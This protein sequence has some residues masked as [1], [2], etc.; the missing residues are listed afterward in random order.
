MV[1][2][3]TDEPEI[4]GNMESVFVPI[5]NDLAHFFNDIFR[6]YKFTLQRIDFR[7]KKDEATADGFVGSRPCLPLDLLP[8]LSGNKFYFH[9]AIGCAVIFRSCKQRCHQS[10]ERLC[11][12]L[13]NFFKLT[14]KEDNF[15]FQLWIR[16]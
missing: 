6:L 9:G 15:L 4:Y 13:Q 5:G 2:I 7:E 10:S 16:S 12:Y 8:P 3:D 14:K 11:I 1:K